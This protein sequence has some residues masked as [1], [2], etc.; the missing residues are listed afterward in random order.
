MPDRA[1]D[2]VP[3]LVG[4]ALAPGSGCFFSEDGIY[5]RYWMT[6]CLVELGSPVAV[7]NH[8]DW[9]DYLSGTGYRNA[10]AGSS[11]GPS[12]VLRWGAV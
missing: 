9:T 12:R 1:R 3:L 8:R 10:I 6:D 7:E 11:Q 5:Q 2:L 4:A